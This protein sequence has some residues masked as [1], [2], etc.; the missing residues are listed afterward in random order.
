MKLLR[1]LCMSACLLVPAVALADSD[2][3]D[4]E[5]IAYTPNN[6]F[7][8]FGYFR[9]LSSNTLSESQGVARATYI[10]RRG[11]LA[12]IPFDASIPIV[13]ATAF[14]PAAMGSIASVA[15][16]A[17]GL[18]DV[19]YF[20]AIAYV[21]PEGAAGE[22]HTIFA[23]NPRITLPTGSYYTDH[24]PSIGANRVTFKPQIGIA[25]RFAKAFTAEVV[26]N[27]AFHGNNSKFVVPSMT[28][29]LGLHTMAQAADVTVDAHL[30]V[31]LAASFFV[32]GSYYL[33][34]N[35][36]ETLTDL[37]NAEATA[38]QTTQSLRFSFGI[39]PAPTTLLLLQLNQDIAASHGASI[40]RWFGIRIS[41][42]FFEQPT[43]SVPQLKREPVGP[44]PRV[45]PDEAP[46]PGPAN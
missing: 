42:V 30:S 7:V 28:G 2:V 11:G 6:T 38:A 37:G 33:Q 9:Q 46:E 20:P 36:K 29:A 35:G 17:S 15:L 10:L 27:M 19:E 18:G 5:A 16:H 26:A 8:G 14:R 44:A 12:I 13:D 34:S 41:H 24:V 32:A 39:R 1:S 31:D 23:F 22:A 25:Q 4:F 45:N 43:P 3:R 21:I 40:E